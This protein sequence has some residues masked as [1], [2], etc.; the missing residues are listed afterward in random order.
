IA[1]RRKHLSHGDCVAG[2]AQKA[3]VHHP[4]VVEDLRQVATSRIWQQHYDHILRPGPA[5]HL[6][7]GPNGQSARAT[8]EQP[9]FPGQPAGQ[10]ERVSV[11]HGDDLVADAAVEGLR[12]EVLSNPLDEIGPAS[13]ARVNRALGVGSDYPYGPARHLLQVTP[14][15][16][17]CAPGADTSDE[18]RNPAVGR[19]P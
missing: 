9:L 13:A 4:T 2:G 5:R 18:V 15:A 1:L 11:T 10:L 19:L 6:E 8:D 17:D 12:P 14:G 7:R 3:I 16:R